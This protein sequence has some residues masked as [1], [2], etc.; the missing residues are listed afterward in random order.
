[1]SSRPLD[2]EAADPLEE[3]IREAS[4][5]PSLVFL[6]GIRLTFLSDVMRELQGVCG[7]CGRVG[8]DWKAA[9]SVAAATR[10]YC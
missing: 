1:M 3:A 9:C 7:A 2:S 6:K 4:E 8:G 5:G 10:A